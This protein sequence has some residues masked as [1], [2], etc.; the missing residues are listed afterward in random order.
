[1]IGMRLHSLIYSAICKTPS[2]A[3][4]YDIK[5]SGFVE[6]MGGKR[7]FDTENV[8]YAALTEAIGECISKKEEIKKEIHASVLK[9]SELAAQNA[10]LA[11]ELLEKL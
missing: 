4:S 9:M 10:K 1:M 3:L 5:V 8:E 2:I 11:T 6:Y 7:C